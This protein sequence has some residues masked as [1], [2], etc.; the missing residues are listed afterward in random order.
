MES[1]SNYKL[2]TEK[3]KVSIERLEGKT[4]TNTTIVTFAIEFLDYAVLFCEFLNAKDEE[5]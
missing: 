2:V 1:N 3:Y 4:K 5:I